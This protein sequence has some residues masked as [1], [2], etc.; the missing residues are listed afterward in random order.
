MS[1]VAVALLIYHNCNITKSFY[2]Y[3]YM[4][5]DIWVLLQ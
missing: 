3:L 1:I 5:A 2:M 4:Y